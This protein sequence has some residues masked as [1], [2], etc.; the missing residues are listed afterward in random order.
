MFSDMRFPV[1]DVYF[2]LITLLVFV[3]VFVLWINH[4]LMRR[5]GL[6]CDS[7]NIHQQ[8]M[9]FFDKH[10]RFVYANAQAKA[11]IGLFSEQNKPPALLKEFISYI[12]DHAVEESENENLFKTLDRSSE[13]LG[14]VGFREV[15]RCGEGRACL[16]EIQK[17]DKDFT[18]LTLIDL[19]SKH[20]QE[21]EN[22][23]LRQFNNDLYHAVEAT[24][25]G[26]LIVRHENENNIIVFANSAFCKAFKMDQRQNNGQTIAE[27][28][29]ILSTEQQE[30]ISALFYKGQASDIEFSFQ[31]KN[32]KTVFYTLK[33]SPV[34][35]AQGSLDLYI[36]VFTD[37]TAIRQKD[38]E[39]FQ[40]KKLEALGQLSAGVAHDFNNMLSIIDGY[41]RL[42]EAQITPASPVSEHLTRI[43]SA[44][45]RGANL[46]K[47]MLTFSRHKI[48][49]ESVIDLSQAMLEQKTMLMPLLGKTIKLN[50]LISDQ[51]LYVECAQD[52]LTQIL[53]NLV[54]NARDAMPGG[55]MLIVE[56]RLC[57]W[58]DLPVAIKEK[59]KKTQDKK[60]RD[61]ACLSV[62]DSGTGMS[63]E[64]I[65]RIFEPFYTTKDQ[66]KGTGLGLSMVYGLVKQVGGHIDVRSVIGAGTS[67]LIYF[68]ISER[69]PSRV[70]QGDMTDIKS[71]RFDG[72]TA[73]VVEDEPE[74]LALVSNMLETI[75]MNVLRAGNGHDAL[76][77]QDE[78]QG[79][80]DVL[81]TDVVMPEMN[82]VELYDLVLSLRPEIK[83]IFMSGYPQGAQNNITLPKE[84]F[85]LAK[86]LRH[87]IL[88]SL[89]HRCLSG[90]LES[91]NWNS[92][93][94]TPHWETSI[95][96]KERTSL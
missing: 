93:F 54:V 89:I 91:E 87:E 70:I 26:I 57:S 23:K 19:N 25:N 2:I 53:M 46:I 12:F 81:L 59:E 1:L 76:V 8:G 43:R 13:N 21:Q 63:K 64:V 38:S 33:L 5:Y 17:S 20:E 44:C 58:R 11:Y 61:F 66:G 16:A 56:A 39:M 73:L 40:S 34:G 18:I 22:L 42:S 84:A 49:V 51:N 9:I 95:D 88:V 92:E 68:P 90:K 67:M 94:A 86:P 83:T 74:L 72:Y 60:R 48:V 82:G 30:R 27:A 62:T 96:I 7:L 10:E 37:L 77:L 79:Q 75:G 50:I 80:I 32:G 78:Y 31:D 29:H 85:F 35:R 28:F 4:R 47:Q 15:I 14:G 65:E 71:L 3:I 36:A 24:N 45:E 55:G 41:A 6:L 52:Y 69:V